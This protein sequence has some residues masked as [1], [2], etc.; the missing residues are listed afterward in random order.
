MASQPLRLPSRKNRIAILGRTGSGKTVAG[1]WHL[2]NADF[3]SMPYIIVNSKDDENI[4]NIERAEHISTSE[5]PKRPG[6][7]IVTPHPSESDA[8]AGM[9]ERVWE[10]GGIGL[11]VDEGF[12]MNQTPRLGD[13]FVMLLTQGRSKQIPMIIHSQRPAWISRFVFSESEFFQVFHLQDNRDVKTISSFLP[14]GAYKRLPDFHSLYYDVG[15]NRLNYLSP[16]PREAEILES[17]DE[18]LKRKRKT[19]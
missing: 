5:I 1:L 3:E 16:V 2:S 6:I 4:G 14:A 11:L 17:I 8:L 19:I 15:K 12:M 10:R 7:Y 9:Y 13:N 18:R